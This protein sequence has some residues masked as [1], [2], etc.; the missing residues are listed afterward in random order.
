LKEEPI[1][2]QGFD[3]WPQILPP[4]TPA[5]MY[6]YDTLGQN[7]SSAG[8]VP[9]HPIQSYRLP[10]AEV[11]AQGQNILTR[12]VERETILEGIGTAVVAVASAAEGVTGLFALGE[13][14]AALTVAEN[15]ARPFAMGLEG[16]LDAFAEARG[17]TTW[18]N[19]ADPVNW[20]P[21][22]IEKLADPNTMVH[23]NLE[24][25]VDVWGGVSRAAAGSLNSGATDWELLQIRQNPQ[26]WDT[27]Q[28]WEGG[29]PAPNPFAK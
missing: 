14:G 11:V 10:N 26:W 21:G 18:K 24:G 1:P 16:G 12:R 28:F 4:S 29:K 7:A 5:G 25:P 6:T 20:K 19:F 13:E 17:A 8:G 22:V 15:A 27:L 9:T 23:F 3:P 2:W